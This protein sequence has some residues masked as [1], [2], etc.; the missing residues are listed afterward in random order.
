MHETISRRYRLQPNSGGIHAGNRYSP[1][2]YEFVPVPEFIE[3]DVADPRLEKLWR[4]I[5]R[6][7]R[8]GVVEL[9]LRL[10]AHSMKRS[11]RMV[12]RYIRALVKLGK[13]VVTER[14]VSH[15]RNL[16]NVFAIPNLDGGVGDKNVVEKKGKVLN[17]TTPAPKREGLRELLEA[18][19]AQ[20][21]EDSRWK[22]A[23]FEHK[24]RVWAE[25]KKWKLQKAYERTRMAMEA[26]VGVSHYEE[27]RTPEQIQADNAWYKA[28]QA[29]YDAEKQGRL[30]RAEA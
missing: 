1:V 30:N 21:R 6:S 7:L 20:D 11:V 18:R 2:K 29:R 23:E 28:E 8:K 9:P 5:L 13:L 12:Q 4:I 3:D 22:R 10:L 16:S 17:T 19:F 14:R 24:A 15:N 27:T 25:S 26:M